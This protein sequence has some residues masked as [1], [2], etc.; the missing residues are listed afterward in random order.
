MVYAQKALMFL[1]MGVYL[2]SEVYNLEE[3]SFYMTL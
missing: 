3:L 2:F 1:I